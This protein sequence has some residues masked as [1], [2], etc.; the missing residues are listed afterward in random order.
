MK[1]QLFL[2]ALALT[3]ALMTLDVFF[4]PLLKKRQFPPLNSKLK[5]LLASNPHN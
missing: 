3:T 5:S 1:K 2:S 4:R